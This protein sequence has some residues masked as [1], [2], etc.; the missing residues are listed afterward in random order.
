MWQLAHPCGAVTLMAQLSGGKVA[1]VAQFL[2]WPSFVCGAF[3]SVAIVF[4]MDPAPHGARSLTSA[5]SPR[6]WGHQFVHASE[7]GIY[8]KRKPQHK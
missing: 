7:S 1:L 6:I 5:S 3:S 4:G 8:Q 2:L